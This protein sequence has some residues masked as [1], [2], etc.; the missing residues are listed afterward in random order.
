MVNLNRLA[1]HIESKAQTASVHRRLERFFREVHLNAAA[2]ARLSVSVL[3]LCGRPWHLAMDRTNWK[4]G[5][6]DLNV[7]VLSVA[8]GHVCVPL[9]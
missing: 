3:G 2:V 5:R 9:L 6:T 4:F 7:L 8:V 1:P